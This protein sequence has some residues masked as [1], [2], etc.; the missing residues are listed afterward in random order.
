MVTDNKSLAKPAPRSEG[1]PT[2]YGLEASLIVSGSGTAVFIWR[3]ITGPGAQRVSE[4]V[5]PRAEREGQESRQAEGWA[6]L[7]PGMVAH[8]Y[9]HSYS[10]G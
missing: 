9:N 2:P 4:M 8:C 3:L 1:I 5:F 6:L 10:G 7:G